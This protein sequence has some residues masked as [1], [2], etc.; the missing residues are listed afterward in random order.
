MNEQFSKMTIKKIVFLQI[1]LKP[2]STFARNVCV[3]LI[4]DLQL[5]IY[6]EILLSIADVFVTV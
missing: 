1:D 6:N 5:F 2:L 4:T 3:I